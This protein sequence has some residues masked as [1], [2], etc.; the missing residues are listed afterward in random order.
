MP[1]LMNVFPKLS[2]FFS[3]FFSCILDLGGELGNF[4]SRKSCQTQFMGVF[5]MA[6]T[7]NCAMG[8]GSMFVSGF[9]CLVNL[10][11]GSGRVIYIGL[12]IGYCLGE[13]VGEYA[14][15]YRLE[16]NVH[17]RH[18]YW[19]ISKIGQSCSSFSSWN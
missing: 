6:Y 11:T 1:N 5:T 15:E 9:Y 3:S 2:A 10:M 12:I 16:N 17:D 13:N 19:N 18:F 7:T 4:D 8:K 14:K